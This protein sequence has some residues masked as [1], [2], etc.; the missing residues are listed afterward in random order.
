MRIESRYNGP[1]GSGNGG[2]SAGVFAAEAGG[3]GPVEVTLR[4]P[5]PLETELSLVGGEVRDPAGELVAEVRPTG[6]VDAVVPPADLDTA[7]AAAAH[8]P[9]L[10]EHPFPGCY[11]CG[12]QRADGLR[13]FPGRLPDGRTAAP[14]RAPEQVSEATVWA[15]LDCPGGWTVLAPGRPYLLGRIAAVVSALPGP[16]DE[17]VVTGALLGVDGRK[18]LVHTSLYGPNGA[19]LGAARATWIGR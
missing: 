11:V 1:P 17:C 10:V 14:F 18:A 9:G 6:L 19:L 13:I 5:P 12:P 7:A 8:Y 4:R 3:T 15:A 16:G 2:W